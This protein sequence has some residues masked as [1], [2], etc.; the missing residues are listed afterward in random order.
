M[1]FFGPLLAAGLSAGVS[2]AGIMAQSQANQ[3]ATN[4]GYLQLYETRRQNREREELA[5]ATRQDAYGNETVY[6]PG[7][8]FRTNTTPLTSSILDAEQKEQLANLTQDAPRNRAAA[9]RRD[10]RS[11]LADE[12]F[13]GLLSEYRNRERPNREVIEHQ[14]LRDALMAREQGKR[15]A[16]DVL[17]RQ[18][19]RMNNSGALAQVAK[20]VSEGNQGS[21]AQALASAR[22]VGRQRYGQEVALDQQEYLP[23]LQ[24]LSSLADGTTTSPVSMSGHSGQITSANERGL[25]TLLQQLSQSQAATSSAYGPLMA[26]AG[27]SVDYGPLAGAARM[28]GNLSFGGG[29]Q[30]QEDNSSSVYEEIMRATRNM[31]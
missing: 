7:I 10:A 14:A 12:D 19:M 22:D 11:Q 24:L 4:L 15:E 25:Q 31:F 5:K 21:L 8:G 26:A 29:Q 17:S 28:L 23:N 6:I 3:N 9:E 20:Q 1:A 2:G 16:T 30:Q 18:A 27:R 13:T